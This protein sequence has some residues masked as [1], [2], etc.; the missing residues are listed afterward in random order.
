MTEEQ[1]NDALHRGN[2]EEGQLFT[3]A[4][5]FTP[6]ERQAH[7]IEFIEFTCTGDK[8]MAIKYHQKLHV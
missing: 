4:E 6:E 5:V 1:V 8:W 7:L 2:I 3:A